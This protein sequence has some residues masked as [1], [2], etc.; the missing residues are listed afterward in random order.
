[1]RWQLRLASGRRHELEQI[2]CK[3]IAQS[4][5]QASVVVE[6]NWVAAQNGTSYD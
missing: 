6:R 5:I 3:S 4:A 1:M 2:N